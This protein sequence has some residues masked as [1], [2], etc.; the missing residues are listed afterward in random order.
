MAQALPVAGRWS[1]DSF[2][3][4]E[5]PRP[6]PADAWGWSHTDVAVT[7]QGDL[8]TALPDGGGLVWVAPDG[9]ASTCPLPV[10]EAHGLAVVPNAAG[11]TVWIADNGTK[12]VAEPQGKYAVNGGGAG[13]VLHVDRAGALL[14]R[15]PRPST[16]DF[17][18]TAVV[19]PDGPGGPLWVADGYG[20][21]AL[22]RYSSGGTLELTVTGEG[23]DLGAFD[24]PHAMVVDRRGGDPV[25]Y[26]T[27]RGTNRLVVLDLDGDV[28]RIVAD[29]D[30]VQPSALAVYDGFLVV[31]ELPGRLTVLDADD[32]V[33]GRLGDNMAATVRPGWPNAVTADAVPVPPE[34]L[35]VDKL[36]SPHGVTVDDHGRLIVTEWVMGGRLVALTP[37]SSR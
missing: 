1:D 31:G 18:P 7:A 9:T 11:D 10:V 16:P 4:T 8:V 21:S 33:V 6:W 27:D 35:P 24:C 25:L 3:W 5:L 17:Q 19:L 32:Q 26:I 23:T 36:N 2:T 14:A 37:I 34:D 20:S 22:H 12:L 15:L 29:A 13:Q 28:V 30:L